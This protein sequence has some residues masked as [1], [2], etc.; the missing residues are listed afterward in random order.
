[1]APEQVRGHRADA[2]SDLFSLGVVMHE[3]LAGQSP[4]RRDTVVESLGAILKEDP[5]VIVPP[6]PLAPIIRRCLEKEPM[7][8]FQSASDLAFALENLSDVRAAPAAAAPRKRPRR[9]IVAAVLVAV[10]LPAAL[11][12]MR[13][14]ER[15]AGRTVGL[16][17]GGG[18]IEPLML[19][20]IIERGL[21]RSGRLVRLLLDVRDAP[22]ALADAA[23]LLGRLGA[24]IDEVKHQRAFS[25]L[26]LERV[27]IEVVVQ[28]RGT[29]HVEQVL[30]A[31]RAEGYDA[32]RI[33]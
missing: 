25:A 30:G 33:G 10:I 26:S 32:V 21:V 19:A 9:V 13:N 31:L 6:T 27:Q 23:A 16:V 11:M 2:R 14:R 20:E 12:L 5:P 15:F 4:F 7:Q 22:G 29:E 24:N 17:L 1:M 28:T 8:R 3:M 18:N